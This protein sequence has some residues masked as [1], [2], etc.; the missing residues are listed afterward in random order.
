MHAPPRVRGGLVA[1]LVT[2]VVGLFVFAAAVVAQLES[3]LGLSPWDTF[4]QGISR[5]TPL[6]FG[7]A[8]VCVS[9]VVVAVAWLLGARVGIGTIANA[10]LVGGF[11]QALTAIG[12]V[13]RLSEASLGVRIGLLVAMVPL[14]GIGSALYLGAGLGAG[15][16]D[17]LMVVGGERTRLRLGVVRV[18]LEF[19]VLAGGFA[20]GGTIGVGTVVFALAVG[21]A[22]EGGFWLL[23]R[24]PLADA[25]ALPVKPAVAPLAGS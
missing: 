1:R 8:I 10:T 6:S 15:P 3:R 24:S 13:D 22:L 5:H 20:L 16:R 9:V 18:A 7:A 2:L 17:S 25:T 23:R 14:I 4:H 21:P 11:I 19:A 12:S